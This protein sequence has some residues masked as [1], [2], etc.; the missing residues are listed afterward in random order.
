[1]AGF[2]D[3]TPEQM[4]CLVWICGLANP[5]LCSSQNGG[6]SAD[7]AQGTQCR[8][9]AVYGH[10]TR[11]QAPHEPAFVNTAWYVSQRR[12]RQ[13]EPITGLVFTLLPMWRTA[14]SQGLRL[15]QQD[16]SLLQ[17]CRTQEGILQ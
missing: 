16:V 8:N 10:Q 15:R 11:C 13:K 7:H 9:L 12:K 4:K 1:M 5:R 3:V 2:N 14:L 6:Q 17:T